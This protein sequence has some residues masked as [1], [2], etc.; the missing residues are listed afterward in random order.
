LP[1]G[2][3]SLGYTYPAIQYD[4][5]EDDRAISGGYV[6]RGG[7]GKI[8][9]LE[10]E[11]IFGDLRSGR[12]FHA[13]VSSLTSAAP[14]P[15]QLLTLI[16][17]ADGQPKSLLALV[18]GG[19]PAGRADL[20]FGQ[21]DDGKIY[22]LTKQDGSVRVLLMMVTEIPADDPRIL[23]ALVLLLGAS[24]VVVIRQREVA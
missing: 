11:Y 3:G 20:R 23:L 6:V 1:P 17:A 10:G 9:D 18:G 8:S 13:P 15:F 7:A 24:A 14:T 2:D 19:S 21:D 5:D 16:D 4:H 22:L 12:V